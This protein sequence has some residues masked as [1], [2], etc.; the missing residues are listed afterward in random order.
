[1]LWHHYDL[2]MLLRAVFIHRLTSGLS[3]ALLKIKGSTKCILNTS[4]LPRYTGVSQFS[5]TA[6]LL[7][8]VH[9][10]F[11][12]KLVHIWTSEF[13]LEKTGDGP[14]VLEDV[15]VPDKWQKFQLNTIC[16]Y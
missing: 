3:Q 14:C 8:A 6:S 11:L 7:L 2:D 12:S 1:M 9:N 15:S 4:K 5:D 13:P 16:V 10:T